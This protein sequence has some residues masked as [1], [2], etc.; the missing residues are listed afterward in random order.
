MSSDKQSIGSEPKD[1]GGT[2]PESISPEIQNF[3]IAISKAG[4]RAILVGGFV[5]DQL[6]G[7]NSKDYDF[8]VYK[9]SLDQLESVLSKFGE[10]ISIGKAFGVLRI[11]GYE[12]D[13]SIPRRDNKI[14]KGHTGFRMDFDPSMSFVDAARR[15]DLTINSIGLD[16][17]TGEVLDPHGGREDLQMGILRATDASTFSEDALRGLRV[18]QFHARL[19]AEPDDELYRLC[20]CLDLSELPGERMWDEFGKMFL[21]GKQPSRGMDFLEKTRLLRFFPEIR[22]MVG[23]LQD[24]EWH[25]EGTVWEHTLMVLDEAA[26]L[27]NG[28]QEHDLVLLYAALCHD[29]GKPLT[30]FEADDGRIRSPNHEAEGVS[31]TEY[32]LNRLRAPHAFIAKVSA[33]VRHHLAPAHFSAQGTTARGYRRL[34]RKLGGVGLSL[35]SLEELA[36]SDHFGRTTPDAIARE[37]PAGE[38]FLKTASEL[39]VEIEPIPDVVKGRHLIARGYKP[40]PEFGKILDKCR[41]LQDE[42]GWVDVDSILN[43]VLESRV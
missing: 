8:E 10:V 21:K 36:R 4:G 43:V 12:I 41:E 3:A 16:P 14:G 38:D 7:M 15:R 22:A 30:T 25:P 28:D 6:L 40:G 37:F 26:K 35:A 23:V 17:L 20:A 42:M 18:A 39:E 27:R 34:A 2:G 29:F 1:S 9:L 19:D 33:L 32:F 31:P 13:F 11:K 24:P 5:R